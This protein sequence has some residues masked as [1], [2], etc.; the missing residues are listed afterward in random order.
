MGLRLRVTDGLLAVAR[1]PAGDATPAWAADDAGGFV[2]VTR[3]ASELSVV[4]AA[5]RV[6]GDVTAERG[7]RRLEV[8]GPLD[9]GLTGVLASVAGPLADAGVP[10]FAV[11]THDTDH[12]L[13]RDHDVAAAAVS[14]RAAGHHVDA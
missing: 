14:L 4:C 6:P 10:L 7:W 2:S 13:V 8:E 3:T 11:S 9:F 5:D 12:I 1:L